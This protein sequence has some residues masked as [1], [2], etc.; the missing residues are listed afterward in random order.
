VVE[1]G[2]GAGLLLEAPQTVFVVGDRSRQNQ[3]INPQKRNVITT[4]VKAS[5][6]FDKGLIFVP[7][8]DIERG[9]DVR[10]TRLGF[11]EINY[12]LAIVIYQGHLRGR[13]R[14]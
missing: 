12:T 5:F 2:D 7:Q 8:S 13:E 9:K 4:L 3:W 11:L 6:K 10:F 14:E 1:G